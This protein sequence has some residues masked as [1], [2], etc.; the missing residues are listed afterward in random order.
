[1]MRLLAESQFF[2]VFG[3]IVTERGW[4]LNRYKLRSSKH[5]EDGKYLDEGRSRSER[6]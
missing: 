3:V 5:K 1:M 6:S 4:L 2:G